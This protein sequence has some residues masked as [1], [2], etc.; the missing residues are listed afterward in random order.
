MLVQP[1]WN[2]LACLKAASAARQGSRGNSSSAELGSV[3]GVVVV[4]L[5]AAATG[6]DV[7]AAATG[8]TAATA[9]GAA[10]ST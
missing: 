5:V 10:L 9:V 1:T 6:V 7:A 8:P 4:V 2:H 3:L